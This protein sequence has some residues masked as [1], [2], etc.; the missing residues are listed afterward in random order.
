VAFWTHSFTPSGGAYRRRGAGKVSPDFAFPS[1]SGSRAMLM[2]IRRASV[3]PLAPLPVG[4]SLGLA[5]VD[6]RKRLPDGVPDDLAARHRVGAPRGRKAAMSFGAGRT[7]RPVE[8]WL[9]PHWRDLNGVPFL[10]LTQPL[11][12]NRHG[13]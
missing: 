2:A 12:V 6:V 10:E 11:A 9:P 7:R 13:Q 5:A 8:V 3:L 4:I 1:S